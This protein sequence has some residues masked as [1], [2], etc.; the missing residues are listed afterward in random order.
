MDELISQLKLSRLLASSADSTARRQLMFA[1]RSLSDSLEEPSDTIQRFGHLNLRSAAVKVKFDINLIEFFEHSQGAVTASVIAKK[2]G[3]DTVLLTRILI[4]VVDEVGNDGF[5]ANHTTHN[6]AK[7]FESISPQY[8]AIPGFLKKTGYQNPT[9]PLHTVFQDAFSTTLSAYD[10]LSQ[11]QARRQ[12]FN[13]YMASR[14]GPELSWLSVY[15]VRGQLTDEMWAGEHKDV[16]RAMYVDIG[17]GKGHQ[18]AQFKCKY[19]DVPGRVILQ[20]LEDTVTKTLS[21]PGVENIT[22]NFF[23]EQPIKAAKFYYIRGVLHNQLVE[24]AKRLLTRTKDAMATDSV[25]LIDELVLGERGLDSYSATVDLTMMA[26]NAS[27]ERTETQWREILEVV[28]LC[29]VKR[30]PYNPATFESVIEVRLL[31]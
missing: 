1:L 3:R 29:F 18:C 2:T 20:D 10:W 17:G 12:V 5:A 30:Y 11:H 25:L 13:D 9:D 28:G 26:A 27:M 24:D 19:P 22:H 14:K 6:V 21:T 16:T 23:D 31:S 4:G 7:N 8:Q 15:P